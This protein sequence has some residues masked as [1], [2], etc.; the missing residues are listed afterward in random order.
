M[1]DYTKKVMDH[2]LNPRNVGEVQEPDAVAEVGNITC[3]DALKITI[4]L[5]DEGKICECKFKT[6]GCASAIAETRP[7]SW[8]ITSAEGRPGAAD[9]CVQK[10]PGRTG[11]P[12]SG[13]RK[14]S[15]HD[16]RTGSPKA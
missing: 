16:D 1:W 6:F 14:G 7:S 13:K 2:F 9:A 8:A 5:D 12:G 11:W 10:N 4:K 15:A 3:G